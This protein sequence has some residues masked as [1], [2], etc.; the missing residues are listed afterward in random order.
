MLLLFE[1]PDQLKRLQLDRG[2][3][4]TAVE[5]MLRMV[6]SVMHFERAATRDTEIRGQ[7]ISEGEKVCM[8]YVAANRD[9]DVFGDPD[10]FDA[11][12]QP[13]PH[14]AFGGG[15]PHFCLGASLARQEIRALFE[16]L[17]DR[18]PGIEQSGP[19][20]RLRSNFIRGIK[21]LPVNLGPRRA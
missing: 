11:G 10:R 15:G 5:E 20:E 2:L 4:P 3:M 8:W 7:R 18:Y 9:G 14:L 17:L 16:E 21:S 19:A 13:N 12:R 6:T 1:F